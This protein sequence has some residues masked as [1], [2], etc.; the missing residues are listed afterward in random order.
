MVVVEPDPGA[1]LGARG[2]GGA[3]VSCLER[4]QATALSPI[5]ALLASGGVDSDAAPDPRLAWATREI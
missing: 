1:P 5:A 3:V 4:D 2:I